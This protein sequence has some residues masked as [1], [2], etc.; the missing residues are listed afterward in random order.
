MVKIPLLSF[1][2]TPI[3]PKQ[4]HGRV[5]YWNYYEQLH[6]LEPYK[7]NWNILKRK[8]GFF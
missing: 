6:H 5:I 3:S 1:V 7:Y 8:L 4:I 2:T